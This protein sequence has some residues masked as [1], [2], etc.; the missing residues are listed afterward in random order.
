[1]YEHVWVSSVGDTA[2]TFRRSALPGGSTDPAEEPDLT[3]RDRYLRTLPHPPN[4][5]ALRNIGTNPIKHKRQSVTGRHRENQKISY[6]TIKFCATQTQ[7][8]CPHEI[9]LHSPDI[10]ASANTTALSADVA[11]KVSTE[12]RFDSHLEKRARVRLWP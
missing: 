6:Y 11:V 12:G 10:M 2:L 9:N 1:M 3:A 8:I 4:H 5:A 7:A